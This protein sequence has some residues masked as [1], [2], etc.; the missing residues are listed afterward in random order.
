ML[1]E[2]LRFVFPMTCIS[3]CEEQAEDALLMCSS[4]ALLIPKELRVLKP[5]TLIKERWVLAAYDSPV[6]VALRRAKFGKDLVLMHRL[7]DLLSGVVKE[8]SLGDIDVITHI[9]TSLGREFLRG[10]D[11]AEVLAQSIGQALNIPHAKLLKRVDSSEQSVK[12]W[13]QRHNTQGRF[14]A[15]QSRPRVLVVDDVCTSGATLEAAAQELL[16]HGAQEVKALSLLSR[17][18]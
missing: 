15:L 4:C 13:E 11:Q 12:S 3:C 10:F 16:L 9:P 5:S 14:E 2:I 6:G 18:I 1:K 17:Q 7:A 8:A